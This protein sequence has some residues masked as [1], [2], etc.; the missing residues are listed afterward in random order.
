MNKNMKK[1]E[2]VK[3]DKKR[4]LIL[5]AEKWLPMSDEFSN[6]LYLEEAKHFSEFPKE[7]ALI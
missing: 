2:D 6:W 4:S 5:V 1:Y 7:F 3:M